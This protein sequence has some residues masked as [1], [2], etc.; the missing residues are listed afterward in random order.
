MASRHEQV[1]IRKRLSSIPLLRES[2]RQAKW[3]PNRVSDLHHSRPRRRLKTE[4]SDFIVALTSY[5]ARIRTVHRTI[6]SLR[7]Q[8]VAPSRIVLVL[9]IEEF[10][11]RHLPAG[12]VRLKNTNLEILWT[13]GNLRSYKK[14][15]PVRAQYPHET[16]VTVD[17]DVIYSR[18]FLGD[19]VAASKHRPDAIIGHR[20][21]EM[22]ADENGSFIPY[23]VLP[24]ATPQSPPDLT[25]LTGVGGIVYPPGS[26]PGGLLQDA[27][28]ARAVC[29]TADD[30]WFWALARVAGTTT[31]CLGSDPEPFRVIEALRDKEALGYANVLGGQNDAQMERVMGHFQLRDRI[32]KA[33]STRRAERDRFSSE[34]RAW[35]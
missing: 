11:E 10:P 16:I 21:W 35:G 3:L 30:I 27:D 17:D 8:S 29:P 5:P 33:A 13:S 28:L 31:I 14:L 15:I 22:S 9:S 26:L 34:R 4:V 24:P 12:L 32:V 6:E 19:L 23:Q 18:D 1:S 25:L 2:Y 20:G 7:R